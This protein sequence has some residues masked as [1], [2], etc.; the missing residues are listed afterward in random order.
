MNELIKTQMRY[1]ADN[2]QCTNTNK[3]TDEIEKGKERNGK[4]TIDNN[5]LNGNEIDG[6]KKRESSTV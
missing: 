3:K 6:K 5:E 1:N 4:H 2:G